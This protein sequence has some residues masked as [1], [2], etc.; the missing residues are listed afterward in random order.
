MNPDA[1]YSAVRIDDGDLDRM[2]PRKSKASFYAKKTSAL[3]VE[4]WAGTQFVLKELRSAADNKFDLDA[5]PHMLVDG[6]CM[7]LAIGYAGTTD[8]DFVKMI[9]TAFPKCIL[10]S[11]LEAFLT[12]APV[13]VIL[14]TQWWGYSR[15]AGLGETVRIQRHASASPTY[16]TDK[17]R[18]S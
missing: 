17:A 5:E 16:L 8:A 15:P 3:S 14:N 1:N 2:A 9:R 11:D 13:K 6:K 4:R 12:R 18:G 10:P 7:P